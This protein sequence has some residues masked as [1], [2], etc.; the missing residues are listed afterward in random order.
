M[1]RTVLRAPGGEIPP[2]DSPNDRYR[3]RSLRSQTVGLRKSTAKSR[4]L[5]RNDRPLADV[6]GQA[7]LEDPPQ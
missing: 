6:F 4:R 2:G 7:L 5:F 1:S 3:K